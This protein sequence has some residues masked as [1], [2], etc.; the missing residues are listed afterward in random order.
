MAVDVE[1]LVLMLSLQQNKFE[2]DLKK[3][4]RAAARSTLGIES[5]FLK[6]NQRVAKSNSLMVN[7]VRRGLG[8]VGLGLGTREV[9]RYADAWTQAGNKVAAASEVAQL[10]GRSLKELN[11]LADENRAGIAET[12]DLYSRLLRSSKG[13]VTS[14]QQ[15]A[16]AT[17]IVIKAFK[18]GGA[19]ATEFQSGVLQL[20]QALGSGFLQGDELRSLRENAPLIAQAI[21]K[22]F[23]TTIGGLKALGAEGKLTSDRVFRAILKAQPEIEAAFAS[24]NATIG[25]G[26]TK[27]RNALTQY[28]GVGDDSIQATE[29]LVAALE[30]LAENLNL[31]VA[32]AGLL[33][34]R[35]V[36]PLAISLAAK[37]APTAVAA[38]AALRLL[39]VQGGAAYVSSMALSSAIGLLGGPIGL[40]ITAGAGAAYALSN[41]QTNSEKLI[42]ASVGLDGILDDLRTVTINLSGDYARLEGSLSDLKDAQDAGGIA[43]TEAATLDVAA[44]NARIAANKRL[45][46]ELSIIAISELADV[47]AQ[48]L[49]VAKEYESSAKYRLLVEEG[50]GRQRGQSTKKASERR[51]SITKDELNSFLDAERKKLEAKVESGKPLEDSEKRILANAAAY[52]KVAVEV[53]NAENK[54]ETLTQK[55]K[56]ADDITEI[57]EGTAEKVD[58]DN[59]VASAVNLAAALKVAVGEADKLANKQISD[60]QVQKI[61]LETVGKPVARAGALAGA[62]FDALIPE[63]ASA[64]SLSETGLAQQRAD[65]VAGAKELAKLEKAESDARRAIK[66]S[67]KSGASRSSDLE[68]FLADIAAKEQAVRAEIA[69]LGLSSKALT[70]NKTKQDLL[71]KA[72]KDGIEVT[73]KIA[74]EIDAHAEAMGRLSEELEQGKISEE[75]FN[76]AVDGIA[77]SFAGAIVAG[78]NLKDSLRSVFQGIARDIL[79][80]GIRSAIMG[81]FSGSS[82][83]G[84]GV[85]GKLLGGIFGGG[86]LLSFDG[87]GF[88][89]AGARTG[90]LDGKGGFHAILHPNETVFDHTKVGG[91]LGVM[92][93]VSSSAAIQQAPASQ[94]EIVLKTEQGVTVEQ[95]GTIAANVSVQVVQAA[96]AQNAESQRRS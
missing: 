46:D 67:K 20:G 73:S 18:A 22:E 2:K 90:G 85:L 58:F 50:Y 64:E 7:K 57:L 26:F 91:N 35:G 72:K 15:V 42:D 86:S 71:A 84:S 65:Y 17:G 29:K 68:G 51:K 77:D 31:V 93:D 13:I 12:V 30:F 75:R 37:L 32:A 24:T 47:K 69:N 52:S 80:S 38:S 36:T 39:A 88:T 66:G 59:A 40:L 61:K 4:N 14:E 92:A 33:A 54:V 16:T 83:G 89:G 76:T 8:A 44:A 41:I 5:N 21:A 60:I 96:S 63:G 43:A 78:E 74:V 81:Q 53:L 23:E 62:K 28:I 25:D 94:V 70:I 45:R 1:R 56:N 27:L 6:M 9:T 95:V 55:I 79:S 48:Q 82:S 10:Q 11:K 19:S 34:L 87:G 49:L 3:A